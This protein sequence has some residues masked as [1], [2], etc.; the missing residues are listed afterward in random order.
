MIAA[1]QPSQRP[2]DARLLV[3]DRRGHIAERPRAEWTELFTRGDVIVANDA[4]TIPASLSGTHIATGA[5]IELRLAARR[6]L[7]PHDI[8][9]WTAVVFGAGDWRTRT[10]NRPLPPP[11]AVGD[12]LALGPLTAEIVAQ[13]GHP[14]LVTI[15]F[16]ATPEIFWKGLLAH[17]RVVQYAHLAAALALWDV[18]APIAAHPVALEPPSAGFAI[19]WRSLRA[20]RA[21]GVGFA[22]LTHAAGLSSTGDDALD[23]RFPL[24]EPY[25]IPAVTARAIAAVRRANGRVIAV[26]TTVVR[27]LEHAAR[28]DGVVKAG[29]GLAD[30]YIDARF[31]LRI[32]DAIFTG[33]HEVASSHHALLRAFVDAETLR[34][35]DLS[36]ELG[37]FRTHEF[38][39]SVL[40]ER[41]RGAG[42]SD[43]AHGSSTWIP[44][45]SL[46]D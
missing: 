46:G 3:V 23:A 30:I 44:A 36:L 33:T 21:R 2:F 9:R 14:R 27:A 15:R 37:Q 24:P 45:A 12:R 31:R 34:H 10:E 26:G 19:D 25:A 16:D 18:Q 38:G 13:H 22:T 6:S 39:D 40:V 42:R 41:T 35:V 28:R 11:L 20:L 4:A 8:A 1:T 7:D 5:P 17:G 29:P 32:V 43:D